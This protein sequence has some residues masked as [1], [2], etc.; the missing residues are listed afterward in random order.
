MIRFT[1]KVCL[2]FLVYT[3][4]ATCAPT[5]LAQQGS[6][7]TLNQSR[8]DLERLL[9]SS[10]NTSRANTSNRTPQARQNNTSFYRQASARTD[11][12]AYPVQTPPRGLGAMGVNNAL[13]RSNSSA[14]VASQ[15]N[16]GS[17]DLTGNLVARNRG[18]SQAPAYN[19][20][21]AATAGVRV[22]RN[23]SSRS[24][25][26]QQVSSTLPQRQSVMRQNLDPQANA[27]VVAPMGG[28][29]GVTQAQ[30]AQAQANLLARQAQD[31]QLQAQQTY[32]QAQQA[33]ALAS[34]MAVN[35]GAASAFR[36][37]GYPQTNLGLGRPLAR[38]AQNGNCAPGYTPVGAAYQTPALS[39]SVGSG[40]QVPPLNI[41]VP[42]QPQGGQFYGQLPGQPPAG[43]G[44]PQFSAQ[45]ARWWTPF[46]SGSGVY[47]PLLKL[48]YMPA[49]S[50]LGQGVIGQ[51][52]AY[53]NGQ[54][55]RNLLRYISP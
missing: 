30:Q 3:V 2:A 1:T 55:V 38:T 40:L 4:G 39:P 52:T 54:P 23:P 44:T 14:R 9:D 29:G 22:A 49:G 36:Q 31:Q 13:N 53:V 45:G 48:Q 46:V 37:T 24:P 47:T 20:N 26:E 51:P 7:Q 21:R 42:G 5:V 41:Q 18:F 35:S 34:Q 32:A 8:A 10:T 16:S 17:N 11:V 50:Y 33:Q 19:P 43:F 25:V 12:Y 28:L 15:I 27:S 6:G